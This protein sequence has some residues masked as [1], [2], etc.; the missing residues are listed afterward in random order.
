[1]GARQAVQ[2]C[3]AM[4]AAAV[5]Q[6][7]A[8]A[9]AS[10]RW[11]APTC[12]AA[13]PLDVTAN[14]KQGVSRNGRIPG[15]GVVA[16]TVDWDNRQQITLFDGRFQVTRTYTP[17]TR[18]IEIAVNGPGEE[19]LLVRF[20]GVEGFSITKGQQVVQG[21]A[22]VATIAAMVNG[23]AVSAFRERIANYERHLIAGG[24]P[25]RWDDVHADALLLTGAFLSS[26]AGDP[27][28]VGRARDLITRRIRGRMR[29]VAFEF[30]DCVRDYELYLLMI[31]EQRT[32]C[33]D[34][35][36]SREDWWVRAADRL[37]CE[38]EFMAGAMAGEGQ[39]ISCTA[40]GSIL[41]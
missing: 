19:A 31:D 3:M 13:G 29:S 24:G 26:L 32:T 39:F 20:G 15:L 33:L 12:G 40:L 18:E 27:G 10:G 34:A 11:E 1:M 2:V 22:P 9:A 8:P 41:A 17:V 14:K 23:T 28:A 36:N 16:A 21:T 5:V 7:A 4:V 25:A 37:G 6:A 35:A 38:V 30:K